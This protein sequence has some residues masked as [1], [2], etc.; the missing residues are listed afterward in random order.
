MCHWYSSGKDHVDG[1]CWFQVENEQKMTKTQTLRMS[2]H[3]MA[4]KLFVLISIRW[5][6]NQKLLVSAVFSINFFITTS[7]QRLCR[8]LRLQ[9]QRNHCFFCFCFF[10][11]VFSPPDSP[12]YL[13]HLILA[14]ELMSAFCIFNAGGKKFKM[15]FHSICVYLLALTSSSFLFFL[16]FTRQHFF[17]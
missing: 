5:N 13:K 15:K 2:R 8:G 11:T 16:F 9:N 6:F 10:N 12:E 14:F 3:I 1:W 17:S 4:R 7:S